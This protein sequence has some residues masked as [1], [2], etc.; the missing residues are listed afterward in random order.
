M[1]CPKSRSESVAEARIELG[2]G[3]TAVTPVTPEPTKP[4]KPSW[5]PT[6]VAT[7]QGPCFTFTTSSHALGKLALK[8][9]L[10]SRPRI[11]HDPPVVDVFEG[12]AGHLLLMGA[13]SAVLIPA[14][15]DQKKRSLRGRDCLGLHCY[16][17]ERAESGFQ[18]PDLNHSQRAGSVL[19][20][21]SEKRQRVE[22]TEVAKHAWVAAL[23]MQQYRAEAKA[24][25]D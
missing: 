5:H 24:P 4:V 25:E 22:E 7:R 3:D 2:S 17:E 13:P 10:Y 20:K 19:M 23:W 9:L 16:G 1:T 8:S 12:I 18:L 21:H 14:W 6:H 15:V 11:L